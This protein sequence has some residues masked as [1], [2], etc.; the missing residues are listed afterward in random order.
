[1]NKK[2]IIILS[3]VFLS[4]TF[5]ILDFLSYRVDK[6]VKNLI[7]DQGNQALGQQVS[8]G[9]IDTSILGSSIKISNIEIKNLDGFKNK[10]IIQIK[11]INANFVL[12][13]LFK[14]TIVI[15]DINI[16][17]A[18]L[19]YEVLI[20]NNKEVKD[21]VSSFKPALKNPS[22]ASVKEIEASKELESKNQS[23]KKNKEFLINQLTINN[24]KINASSE[25]LDI[26]KDINLNKMSF[27]NVGTAEKS[28]K[29][30]EVLQMVFAN[31]LLNIN[32]EVI[33]GDLKNK[34]KDKVKNLKNKISP[35]S[36][37][38]LERTFR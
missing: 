20:N 24:A 35:E 25:F 14:D 19:Y 12:T 37:K 21:N 15:K 23:K 4:L 26:N 38:K 30:K 9:K 28:T 33:Q 13:S 17:G 32:N 3:V 2:K 22:G 1:M 16:D 7:I 5:L 6:I 34:I 29:F 8:V 11:N 31:V 10:N 36:L 27:N 18:T